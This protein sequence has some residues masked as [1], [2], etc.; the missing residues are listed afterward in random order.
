MIG[1]YYLRQMRAYDAA[2]ESLKS[3][4]DTGSVSLVQQHLVD[5]VDINTIVRRFGVTGHLPAGV[6]GGVFGDFSGVVDYEDA[7]A[8]VDRA[9]EGFMTLPAEVRERFGN[10]PGRL[11]G[12]AQNVPEEMLHAELGLAPIAREEAKSAFKMAAKPVPAGPVVD[13]AP[14][15]A[16]AAPVAPVKEPVAGSQPKG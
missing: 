2:A 11:V 12:F 15:G 10:D 16:A 13:A 9:R 5:E 7:V 6:P 3:A 14:G 4:L 8:K 1:K